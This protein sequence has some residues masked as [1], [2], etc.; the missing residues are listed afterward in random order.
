MWSKKKKKTEKRSPSGFYILGR[1]NTKNKGNE[2]G[3]CLVH[4]GKSNEQSAARIGWAMESSRIWRGIMEAISWSA[5]KSTERSLLWGRKPL[6]LEKSSRYDLCFNLA[7]DGFWYSLMLDRNRGLCWWIR[8]VHWR[9]KSKMPHIFVSEQLE[10]VLVT[11]SCLIDSLWP[12][13][14]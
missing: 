1:G 3:P 7:T 14:L 8:Y 10:R 13:G 4:V 9:K 11:Q 5:L 12:H 2:V 6:G